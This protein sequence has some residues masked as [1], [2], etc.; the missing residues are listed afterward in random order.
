VSAEQPPGEAEAPAEQTNNPWEELRDAAVAALRFLTLIP[1]PGPFELREAALARAVALFPLVGALVG[2]LLALVGWACGLLWGDAVRAVALTVAW[3]ALTGGL[4][5]DGLSDTFD[6]VMSWRPRERKLEIMRDSRV[7][8]MGVLALVA[9]LGLKAALLAGEGWLVGV[10]LAPALGRWAIGLGL[11][12]FP[13]AR[14]DGLGA[15]TQRLGRAADLTLAT[16]S[17]LA[18][19]LA[20]GELRGL[21]ALLLVALATLALA[22]WWTRALGG[23]TGDTY[24]AL[25]ELGE[26]V[27]LAALTARL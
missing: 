8:V 14:P 5:L 15:S 4:H 10:L 13:A 12:C 7:G 6:G 2:G 22:R 27:A 19:A 25:C 11:R 23:L 1:V 26:V 21:L 18:L 9:V 24:G 3:A 16:L 17:A 20:L